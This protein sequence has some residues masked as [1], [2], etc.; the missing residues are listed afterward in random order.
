MFER[1]AGRGVG[2]PRLGV[3][4]PQFCV[5]PIDGTKYPKIPNVPCQS[6]RCPDHPSMRLVGGNGYRGGG[7]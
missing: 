7:S 1:G 5:C 2:G 4:P 3:G 6:R